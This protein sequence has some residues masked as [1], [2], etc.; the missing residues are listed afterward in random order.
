MA[1]RKKPVTPEAALNRMAQ[2][3]SRSEQCEFE[4]DKKLF[5]MGLNPLQRKEIIEYLKAN[6]YIDNARY[7]KSFA[8]DKVR[9]SLWGPRKIKA[10]LINHK[11]SASL[12]T[13]AIEAIKEEDI[14]T[15]LMK[16][17]ESKSR[18]LDLTGENSRDERRK[19]F[20]YLITR[21][22]S[23]SDANRAVKIMRIQ[24]EEAL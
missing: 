8:N 6:R 24:Q 20:N 14:E 12:I 21:G 22:F 4:I 23:G 17:A 15:A 10:A 7:A 18:N 9:F 3:C 1:L 2:L 19:L 5:N 11:I 16:S 13:E